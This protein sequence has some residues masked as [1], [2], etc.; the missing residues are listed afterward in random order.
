MKAK[1][2]RGIFANVL[3]DASFDPEQQPAKPA[4][5]KVRAMFEEVR[6]L[7]EKGDTLDRLLSTGAQVAEFDPVD[8]M[9]SP[10][11]DRFEGAYDEAAIQDLVESM[12]ERGQISPGLVRPMGQ[13]YQIVYGRRRLA[14]A[15]KLEIKF[16]ALVREMTDEEAVIL[17]GEENA[18]RNDLTYIEKCTFALALAQAGYARSVICSSLSTTKSHVSEM[19]KVASTVP[20]DVLSAIGPAPE[21]GR[22]RWE[23]FTLAWDSANS[24]VDRV[25]KAI[26]GK[27][28]EDR[29]LLALSALRIKS[30]VGAVEIRSNGLLLAT[31]SGARLTLSKGAPTGFME[32]LTSR[33]EELHADFMK[34]K[35]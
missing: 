35:G 16:R 26:D 8:I 23:D 11:S 27:P 18:N 4:S 2:R 28:V 20:R 19:L 5:P 14:A 21:V 30:V 33:M 3:P 32:Y 10:M 22:R 31:T 7:Q 34:T 25:R 15:R 9:P 1:D 6:E 13:G 29:F 17:Q 12:R 24:P